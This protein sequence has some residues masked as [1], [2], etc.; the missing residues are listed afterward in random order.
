MPPKGKRGCGKGKEGAASGNDSAG[1][2]ADVPK[3][4]AVQLRLDTVCVK[5]LAKLWEPWKN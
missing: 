1:R 2:K 4:A 3:V 5:H